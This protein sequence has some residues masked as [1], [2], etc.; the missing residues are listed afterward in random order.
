MLCNMITGAQ[1]RRRGLVETLLLYAA[2][3][4]PTLANA[5]GYRPGLDSPSWHAAYWLSALPQ[6][7]FLLWGLHRRGLLAARGGGMPA[8]S[9]VWRAP[10]LALV[11]LALAY[12]LACAGYLP[13]IIGMADGYAIPE[14]PYAL[15]KPALLPLALCTSLMTGYREEVFF[16]GWLQADV[17]AAG[18]PPAAAMGISAL[19]FAVLHAWEGWIGMLTALGLGLL[20]A[21]R[22]AAR[23]DLHEAALGHAL[24]DFAAMVLSLLSPAGP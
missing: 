4:L 22:Y 17:E 12:G 9:I 10:L 11:C 3:F 15:T 23:R 7:F 2:L 8:A 24:Y 14:R 13:S 18:A 6:A 20:L 21:W 19:G 16:R 1:E 5:P